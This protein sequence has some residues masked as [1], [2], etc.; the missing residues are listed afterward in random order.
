MSQHAAIEPT[1][2]VPPRLRRL[3]AVDPE[4]PFDDELDQPGRLTATAESSDAA[5]SVLALAFVLPGGLPNVPGVPPSWTPGAPGPKPGPRLRLVVPTDPATRPRRH[6]RSPAPTIEEE[7]GPQPTPR[8]ELP[9]PQ[10]WAA[11]LV[12]AFVEVHAGLRPAS[13]LVRWTTTAVQEAV[14]RRPTTGSDLGARERRHGEVVRSV[15]ASEPV[16]G[17]VE[18]SAVVQRGDRCRAIALRLEGIDG[19]WQCTALQL[20]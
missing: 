3:P 17:V 14:V 9:E 2:S 1:S 18:V 19:R 7:F 10:L 13:Q 5:Q 12:Q 20:G 8:D 4:P 11:R 15:R 16:D 6:R